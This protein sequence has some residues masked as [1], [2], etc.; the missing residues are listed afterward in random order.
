MPRRPGRRG[1]GGKRSSTAALERELVAAARAGLHVQRP[2][3]M[4]YRKAVAAI[5]LGKLCKC[6]SA[7]GKDSKA[8]RCTACAAIY[9]KRWRAARCRGTY[10]AS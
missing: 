7:L 4:N 9:M 5:G 3:L 6:G 8:T 1:A 2:K 10:G